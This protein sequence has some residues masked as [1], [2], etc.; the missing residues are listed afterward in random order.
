MLNNYFYYV[1]EQASAAGYTAQAIKV[2]KCNNLLYYFKKYPDLI[3]ITPC[4]T[5][6]EAEKTAAAWNSPK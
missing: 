5:M 1:I 6:K 3:S 2:N 4:N